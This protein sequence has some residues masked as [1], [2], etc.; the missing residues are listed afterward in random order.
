MSIDRHIFLTI[1][2]SYL[3]PFQ[4]GQAAKRVAAMIGVHRTPNGVEAKNSRRNT[5][6]DDGA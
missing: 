5:G 2:A 4:N 6:L 1:Y 3:L